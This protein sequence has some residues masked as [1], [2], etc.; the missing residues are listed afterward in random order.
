VVA[1]LLNAAL[2]VQT[3]ATAMSPG[4]VNN[5]ILAAIGALLPGSVRAPAQRPTATPSPA[6]A[7]T[8]GS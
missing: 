5:A 6:V 3:S 2:F 1:L 7:V 8:G 4:D